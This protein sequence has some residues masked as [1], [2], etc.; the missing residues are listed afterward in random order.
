MIVGPYDTWLW[1]CDGVLLDSNRLK[2][3]AFHDL[4]RPYGADVADALVAYHR[5]H[6]GRSRFEK[7]RYLLGELLGLRPTEQHVAELARAYGA[8]VR[9]R[10]LV[11]PP[12]TGARAC[13]ARRP[14]GC[15]WYVVSGGL[16]DEVRAALVAQG[17]AP[18]FDAIHGSPRSKDQIVAALG[19]GPSPRAVMLGD[20]RHDHEV[21]V[22]FGL[23]FVF[24]SSWSEMV[25][26][27][28]YVATHR[29]PVVAELA[30]LELR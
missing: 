17:L 22:R 3:E 8:L 25:D 27:R 11:C 6:G 7:V 21:A 1:D 30:E 23:D 28:D 10:L 13:V 9:D 12:T 14:A 26:W 16:E 20:S 29:V 19:L 2:T 4:A 5:R 24:V 18:Q 15:R